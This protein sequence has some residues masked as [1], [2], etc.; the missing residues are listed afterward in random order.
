MVTKYLNIMNKT[1]LHK[2]LEIAILSGMDISEY[3]SL[4]K[5]LIGLG[6]PEQPNSR[7]LK[8]LRVLLDIYDI[9]SS[10]FTANGKAPKELIYIDCPVCGKS[11]RA[12]SHGM[13]EGNARGL[14]TTCS[15]GCANT[16]FRSGTDSPL[17]VSGKGAYR[18]KALKH[19]GHICSK[20][21]ELNPIVL[22]VHHKDRD[23]CNNSIDNL[24][25]LCANCHLIEHRS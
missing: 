5:V 7:L 11:F 8:E 15:V 18:A 3:Y 23:R 10:H 21:G 13:G 24:V 4:T 16:F 14:Q 1:K 17:Y 6:Y 25:V 19:Y 2:T 22:E 12:N 9:D 20:C